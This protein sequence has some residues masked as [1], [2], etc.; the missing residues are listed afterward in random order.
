MWRFS[1]ALIAYLA[2]NCA[3]HRI[4]GDNLCIPFCADLPAALRAHYLSQNCAM[5]WVSGDMI[6]IIIR[7]TTPDGCKLLWHFGSCHRVFF[8]GAVQLSLDRGWHAWGSESLSKLDLCMSQNWR[9]LRSLE[10]PIWLQSLLPILTLLL[11]S[12]QILSCDC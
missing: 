12:R 11:T 7:W 3:M 9:N 8:R 2:L 6:Y 10:R 4:S 5:Y 1:T